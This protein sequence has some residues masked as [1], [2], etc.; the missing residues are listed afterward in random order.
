MPVDRRLRRCAPLVLSLFAVFLSGC[1][2]AAGLL[3]GVITDAIDGGNSGDPTVVLVGNDATSTEAIVQIEAYRVDGAHAPYS[4]PVNTTAGG[5]A[6]LKNVF[7]AGEHWVRVIYASGWRSKPQTILVVKDATATV[8]F[9]HATPD[10]A[11]VAGTWFGS[12]ETSLGVSHTYAFTLNAG[13]A[14]G[15]RT[16]DGVVDAATGTLAETS[17]GVWRV[18]WSG[19]T[20]SALV[21]DAAS[22]HAGLVLDD[23]SV[24]AL[25]KGASAP[26]PT[27][28][29]ADVVGTWLG[30]EVRF[31][32]APLAPAEL[33]SAR[34]TVSAQQHWVGT[35]GSGDDT[36]GVSPLVATVPAY[37]R[38]EGDAESDTA[39]A[40]SLGMWLTADKQFAF[41][42]LALSAGGA[43]PDTNTFQFLAKAP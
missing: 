24:G 2:L 13:G 11:A 41:V 31:V 16:I 38:F 26:L 7:D 42:R 33:D 40:L 35:D 5:A 14:A 8:K 23:G 27:G 18:T 1:G 30:T 43:F 21:T 29:D 39:V 28:V 19:G 12:T 22:G 34:A 36:T 20:V 3:V 10:Y 25:Q 4:Y 32:G 37:L 6:S 17:E 9:V 15:A